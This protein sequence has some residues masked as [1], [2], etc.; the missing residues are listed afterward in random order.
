VPLTVLFLY[1][2]PGGKR[3]WISLVKDETG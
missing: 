1:A 3:P 2:S